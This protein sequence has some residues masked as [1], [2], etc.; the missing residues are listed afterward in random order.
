MTV[1]NG[2]TSNPDV[3]VIGAGF[4]GL[5]MVHALT[6]SGFRV[7]AFEAAPDV[8]GT[9]YWNRYPGARCDSESLTYCY[10][11]DEELCQDWTWTDRYPAGP[12]VLAYLQHVA[13]R[14]KLR[15]HFK[16]NAKIL[17]AT[18]KEDTRRWE[19]TTTSGES[20]SAKF[21]ISAVGNLS[22]PATPAVPGIE[23]YKG[24]WVHTGAWPDEPIDFTNKRVAVIGTGSS[25]IQISQSIAKT[26]G[27][28]TVFQRTPTYTIPLRNMPL[29]PDIQ[30]LW[31]SKY[32]DLIKT[33]R[34]SDGG[35][36]FYVGTKSLKN[37]NPEEQRKGLQAGWNLGGF[38]FMFGIF[39]D[40]GSDHDA[41]KVAADFVREQVDAIV[42][43]PSTAALL[44]PTSYPLGAKRIP[45][46]TDYYEIFNQG[47][48]DLVDLLKNPI[49]QMTA[50]GLI[51]GSTEH[52]FDLVVFATGFEA[53]TGPL[54]HIDIT[55]KNGQKLKNVWED[56]PYS[57]L[58][59]AT[60][61]F[62]NMFTVAGPGG[63]GLISNVPPTLEQHVEWVSGCINYLRDHKVDEI[64]ASESSADEWI[65]HVHAEAK[66]TMYPYAPRSWYDGSSL[67]G[68]TR[69]FPIYT[70]GF[71][72]YRKI[73]DNVAADDYHGFIIHKEGRAKAD[74]VRE[75]HP[76]SWYTHVL[77]SSSSK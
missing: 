72:N 67:T 77:L 36:P 61:G 45:L 51:A 47:N 48:V 22:V 39:N 25:G 26:A 70:G 37:A 29:D 42:K 50:N 56:G 27:H 73:C 31:K 4:S 17:S 71:G 33:V 9:W 23:D 43:D 2:H 32:P 1:K 69:P 49:T 16:F 65:R 74:P 35:L 55:G 54:V 21:F 8:G 38:R 57:Y 30:R 28:L 76:S 66:K 14:F 63:P 11:F 62:P 12:E 3:I 46:Q 53:V 20:V 68:K 40:I 52:E 60:P 64:E 15:Q 44:K 24:R 13:E 6:K 18:Y 34:Y 75:A 5:Y 41:N 10:T 59:L 58:G 7:Q 19:V